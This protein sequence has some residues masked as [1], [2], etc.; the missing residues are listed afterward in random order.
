M[1][2]EIVIYRDRGV[3][4]ETFL[5]IA[6]DGVVTGYHGHVDLGTGLRTALTQIIAEELDVPPERVRVVMGDTRDTPDQGPTI[7][8]ESIQV[9][10]VPL[11]QAAAQA[12]RIVLA[13]AAE[14]LQC[15]PEVLS[16]EAG[17]IRRPHADP[18]PLGE[19]VASQT[20]EDALDPDVVVKH[21]ADYLVVGTS[22]ARVDLPAKV[23][24]EPTYVHDVRVPGMLHGHV[25][26]PPYAGRDSGDFIGR[27]LVAVDRASVAAM[28]G[29]VALVIEGDFVGVVAEREAQAQA[30]AEALRIEW[31]RPPALPD[32][33]DVAAALR[34][35]P[36]V[37]RE[38][39]H[40][41]D[42]PA[43][44]STAAKRLRRRYTWPWQL[45]GSIGPSCAVAEW[46]D[47][48]LTVWSGTQ[49]PH[50]LR[51]DLA[52]LT[53]VAPAG[54]EIRRFEAAG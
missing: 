14:L 22:L 43:A 47:G 17:L 26:R 51:D 30:I 34:E 27:S 21:P 38:L 3:H 32:L 16:L 7:A 33:T 37:R 53:G 29:F 28:P 46:R 1:A 36:S 4:R 54:I 19:I 23:R 18:I 25:V 6:T 44:L 9:A 35:H 41:G 45:H 52:A 24:G 5:R 40:R 39:C 20:V 10:A 2:G 11:R 12:R 49:N 31:R 13:R 48:T 50:A 42:V 8:S 15:R